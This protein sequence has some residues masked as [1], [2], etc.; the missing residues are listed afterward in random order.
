MSPVAGRCRGG[1]GLVQRPAGDLVV[2]CLVVVLCL[3]LQQLTA[4]GLQAVLRVVRHVGGGLH[5]VWGPALW[6]PLEI[7]ATARSSASIASSAH[8]GACL[9]LEPRLLRALLARSHPVHVKDQ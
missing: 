5:G 4:A 7:R 9:G 2:I 6:R 1:A 3:W 8:P